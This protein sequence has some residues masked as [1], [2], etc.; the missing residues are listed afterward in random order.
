MLPMYC[1]ANVLALKSINELDN[2]MMSRELTQRDV[3]GLPIHCMLYYF[4]STSLL[5]FTDLSLSI[6][7]I[8]AHAQ[9]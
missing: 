3:N 1:V 2:G 5:L 6:C 7:N 9:C 4:Y 8:S